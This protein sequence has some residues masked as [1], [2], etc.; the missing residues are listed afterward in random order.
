MF[1]PFLVTIG[2]PGT[3]AANIVFKY[4][5]PMDCTMQH[6][7][8][9]QSNAGDGTL[10]IGTS[11][12]DDIFLTAAAMGKSG[13]PSEKWAPDDFRFLATPRIKKGDIIVFTIDYDGAGGTAGADVF[14]VATFE[15]G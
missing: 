11:A 10:K 8:T 4:T 14:I 3:L 1:R 15:E 13:A 2:V 9:V 5:A 12:D 6:L 7:S